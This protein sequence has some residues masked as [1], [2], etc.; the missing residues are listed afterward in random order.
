VVERAHLDDLITEQRLKAEKRVL[1]ST[2]PAI[3]KMYGAE[4]IIT[5]DITEYNV[6]VVT[7]GAGMR[8]SGAGGSVQ[9]AVA[10]AA[11][12]LRIV[13]TTTGR[14]VFNKSLRKSIVG[15]QVGVNIFR[16]WEDRLYEINGGIANQEP[17]QLAIRELLEEGVYQMCSSYAKAYEN[18]KVARKTTPKKNV[19][20]DN[21]RKK[22]RA[23][24]GK[25]AAVTT[26]KRTPVRQPEKSLSRKVTKKA[27]GSKQVVAAKSSSVKGEAP[28]QQNVSRKS[29][30]KKVARTTKVD[31]APEKT[32]VKRIQVTTSTSI[33][34]WAKNL[35]RAKVK[36]AVV[37]VRQGPGL[38]YREAF[39]V[40]RNQVLFVLEKNLVWNL[41]STPKGSQGWIRSDMID[42]EGEPVPSV[43]K[44]SE[45][46]QISDPG[47][48]EDIKV[49]KGSKSLI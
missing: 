12:D 6:D 26:K 35:S 44:D 17:V 5:G 39:Q 40:Q 24:A 9:V 42:M 15:K 23:A 32:E 16:F 46:Q 41:V 47:R 21:G 48:G 10:T 13:E 20:A 33:P 8:I 27:T 36:N 34:E 28:V 43:S 19:V 18:K 14:I 2:G 31:K 25:L 11:I 45:I 22:T 7:A 37:N 4:Y 1:S 3:G 30:P 49:L 29:L 38:N